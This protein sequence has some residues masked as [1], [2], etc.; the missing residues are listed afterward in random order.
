MALRQHPFFYK[1]NT[2]FISWTK[3]SG[4]VAI[5]TIAASF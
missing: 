2:L 1:S 5:Y 4:K 3:T